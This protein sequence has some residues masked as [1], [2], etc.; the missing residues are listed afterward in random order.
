MT[1]QKVCLITGGTSGIGR[2]TA[3]A[4]QRAGWQVFEI[5]RR[6]EGLE[7]IP[8]LS[9]DVTDAVGICSAVN[10]ILERTGRIDLLI[11]NAGFGISGAVEFTET[12]EARRQFDVNFFG[13]VNLNR[14]VLP[15][16]RRQGRGRIL[17][18]SSVAAMVPIPFQAYYSAAKAAINSYTLALANEVRPFGIEICAVQPGD[19]RTGFTGARRKNQKGDAIYNGQITRSVARMERDEQNGMTPEA[20]ARQ[21]CKIATGKRIRPICTIGMGYRLVCVAAKLLPFRV[22]NA[23]VRKRYC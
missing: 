2:E 23:I 21:I 20:A 22:L 16:M 7:E 15:V 19:I 12:E 17:Q 6:Q 14:A 1:D 5:S 18:I 10:R 9:A 3:L 8:H 4:L 13:M 11:N